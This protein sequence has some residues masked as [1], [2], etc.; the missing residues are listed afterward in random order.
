MAGSFKREYGKNYEP[1]PCPCGQ[2][3]KNL[4]E[5]VEA[6]H[7]DPAAFPHITNPN[8]RGFLIAF[9]ECGMTNRAAQLAGISRYTLYEPNWKNNAV[10]QAAF[11]IARDMSDGILLD[12]MRQRAI[13]GT[14]KQVGWYQGVAGGTEQEYSEKF[15]EML[16]K[17]AFPEDFKGDHAEVKIAAFL[18]SI[19]VSKLSNEQIARIR[20]GETIQSVLLTDGALKLSAGEK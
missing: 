18:Q 20:S 8:Q 15:M 14:T 17:K 19:D 2:E 5:R 13:Y 9:S 6:G 3:H 12:V 16:V 10:F 1:D 11:A 7:A 4:A